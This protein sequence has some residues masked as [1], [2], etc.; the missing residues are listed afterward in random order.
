MAIEIFGK[1]RS[2]GSNI[3]QKRRKIKLINNEI[4]D[5]KEGREVS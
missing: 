2:G 5:A 3:R 4:D 1:I